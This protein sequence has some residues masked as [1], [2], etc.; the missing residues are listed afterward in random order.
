MQPGICQ[1]SL[2][3]SLAFLN[4]WG[5]YSSHKPELSLKSRVSHWNWGEKGK[6]LTARAGTHV[7]GHL[8]GHCWPKQHHPH[9]LGKG[10]LAPARATSAP[11]VPSAQFPAHHQNFEVVNPR[12][13]RQHGHMEPASCASPARGVVKGLHLTNTTP[14]KTPALQNK[15]IW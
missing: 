3:L 7:S 10:L 12:V 1:K 14:K 2:V 11:P 6:I 8:L 9:G 13:S 4:C 15:L 5:F